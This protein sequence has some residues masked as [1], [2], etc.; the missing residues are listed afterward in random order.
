MDG[1]VLQNGEYK[2]HCRFDVK[3]K[4]QPGS[5]LAEREGVRPAGLEAPTQRQ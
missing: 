5:I 2:Y 1:V 4:I 3:T